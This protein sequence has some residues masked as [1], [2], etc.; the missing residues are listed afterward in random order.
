MST[1]IIDSE[2]LLRLVE[3]VERLRARDSGEGDAPWTAP[4]RTNTL[5]CTQVAVWPGLWR[6]FP[7]S[8]RREVLRTL[9]MLLERSMAGRMSS[10]NGGEPDAA[11]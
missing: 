3:L 11:A 2:G 1:P 5:I 10:G 4:T 9:S 8:S 6:S 7:E